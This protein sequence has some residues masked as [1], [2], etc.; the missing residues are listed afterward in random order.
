MKKVIGLTGTLGAGK[1]VV[2]D[3]LV[4]R[5]NSY[6]VSLSSIIMAEV[7]KKRMNFNRKALQELGNDLRKRY[8]THI[9]AMLAIEYLQRDKEL[10][11]VDGIRNPG[12]IDFLKKKFGNGFVLIAVDAPPEQRF[13]KLKKRG[14][15]RDP[16]TWEEFV[17]M[18]ERD[19][20]KGEPD[21]GQQVDRCL[22][23]ADF[24]VM[25]DGTVEQL[26]NKVNE[27]MNKIIS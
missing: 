18:D 4:R 8:G 13:E 15:E 11:I 24:T 26:E 12:E 21:Y 16:K 5:F 25:N 9:L 3:F 2:K 10:I 17:E 22:S 27:I 14:S 23:R 6:H 7:E 1:N 19:K 20:G